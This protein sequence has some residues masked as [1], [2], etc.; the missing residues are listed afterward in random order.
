MTQDRTFSQYGGGGFDIGFP[1][2]A[3]GEPPMFSQSKQFL[4]VDLSIRTGAP[5]KIIQDTHGRFNGF[6]DCQNIIS[7][8][9]ISMAGIFEHQLRGQQRS[10]EWRSNLVL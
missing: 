6:S 7:G 5:G 9:R 3:Y 10:L 2:L 1:W 4:E 8:Y